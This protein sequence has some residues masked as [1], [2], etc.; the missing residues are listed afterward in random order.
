MI[1]FFKYTARLRD[2]D[3]MESLT[4]SAIPSRSE[5]INLAVSP[6]K[7][8]CKNWQNEAPPEI[9]DKKKGKCLL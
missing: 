5:P 2:E 8:T 7:K 4:I 6:Q 3:A 1:R 9:T